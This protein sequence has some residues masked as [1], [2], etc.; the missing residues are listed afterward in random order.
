ML[1][2]DGL[3]CPLHV[4]ERPDRNSTNQ[5]GNVPDAAALKSAYGFV[6]HASRQCGAAT[7]IGWSHAIRYGAP[8]LVPIVLVFSQ[9]QWQHRAGLSRLAAHV[10]R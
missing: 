4:D 3:P 9:R 5:P 7:A 6:R 8:M 10:L 2:Q 1:W